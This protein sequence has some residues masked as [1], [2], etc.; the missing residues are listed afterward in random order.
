MVGGSEVNKD[1][2]GMMG[3]LTKSIRVL[4]KMTTRAEVGGQRG[5]F[6]GAKKKVHSTNKR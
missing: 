1:A 4:G 3:G 2:S 6:S 5:M